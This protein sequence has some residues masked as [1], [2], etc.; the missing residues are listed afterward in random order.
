M[1]NFA[2]RI[3]NNPVSVFFFL[4][5]AFLLATVPA[6]AGGVPENL[7]GQGGAPFVNDSLVQGEDSFRQSGQ[8]PVVTV[9]DISSSNGIALS[10]SDNTI[11]VQ[12]LRGERNFTLSENAILKQDGRILSIDNLKRGDMVRMNVD[13]QGTVM[14]VT[15]MPGLFA[16]IGGVLLAVG[17]AG[18][19]GLVT[20]QAYS[21]WHHIMP[22]H[23][24]T[25]RYVLH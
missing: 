1:K 20:I 11:S 19:V 8:E 18:V 22:R 13:S 24:T 21:R 10:V 9:E 7:Q 2:Y 4:F 17:F 5:I 23:T 14:N 3:L 15:K 25:K 6:R 16:N 12:T